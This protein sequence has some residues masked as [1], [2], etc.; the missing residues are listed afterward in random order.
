MNSEAGANW[1]GSEA[2]KNQ[3]GKI[4]QEFQNAEGVPL[5]DLPNKQEAIELAWA[6]M[7][8]RPELIS[9]NPE[10]A[11]TQKLAGAKSRREIDDALRHK[12][13]VESPTG[14]GLAIGCRF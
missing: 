13:A 4:I 1:P 12:R 11:L 10:V 7:Q 8:S 3:L 5:A 9:E 6:Y 14:V 2:N